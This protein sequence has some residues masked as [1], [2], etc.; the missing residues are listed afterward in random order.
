[1]VTV[2]TEGRSPAMAKYVKIGFPLKYLMPMDNGW[3][4]WGRFGRYCKRDWRM[5]NRGKS[6]GV[7]LL[8]S[9]YGIGCSGK[10][11]RGR[12]ACTQWY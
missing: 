11:G 10:S 4:E 7:L 1:M 8:K 3:T 5:R 2:S 6:S 12:G 9:G